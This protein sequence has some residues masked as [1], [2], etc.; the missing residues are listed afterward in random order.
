LHPQRVGELKLPPQQ[1]NQLCVDEKEIAEKF[2][3]RFVR[4]LINR[5]DLFPPICGVLLGAGSLT[6][7]HKLNREEQAQFAESGMESKLRPVNSGSV[8]AKAALSTVLQT[9]S[10]KN[11]FERI[12]PQ[13]LS[14]GVPRGIERLIHTCRAAYDDGW[15]LGRNDYQN[16]FNTLSR[17]KMLDASAVFPEAGAVFNLFTGNYA[18]RDDYLVGGRTTSGLFCGNVFVLCR[19]CSIGRQV[20]AA[21]P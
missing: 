5:T 15:L 3:V 10:A 18:Q 19:N 13:Q 14:L 6:P 21:L 8:L 1:V 11:A 4:V 9:P 17:Q 20:A 12:G 2:L 16:G 7:L